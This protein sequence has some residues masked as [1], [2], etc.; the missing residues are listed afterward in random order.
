MH[1]DIKSDNFLIDN[2]YNVKVRA[3]RQ[4]C[5]L[6]GVDGGINTSRF[7]EATDTP[8]RNVARAQSIGLFFRAR[9]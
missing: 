4:C 1:R 3:E 6:V 5:A 9:F 2:N 7:R 8:V